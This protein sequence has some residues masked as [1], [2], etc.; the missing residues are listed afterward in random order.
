MS[1]TNHAFFPQAVRVLIMSAAASIAL[2]ATSVHAQQAYILTDAASNNLGLIDLASGNVTNTVTTSV[3]LTG[4]LVQT[5][6]GNFFGASAGQLYAVDPTSGTATPIGGAANGYYLASD[7]TSL[8]GIL[9]SDFSLLYSIDK[10]TGA[11]TVIGSGTGLPSTPASYGFSTANA[12]L[13]VLADTGSGDSL[14]YQID[15]VTGTAGVGKDTGV[16]G[17]DALTNVGGVL[18]AVNDTDQTIYQIDALSGLASPTAASLSA[19]FTSSGATQTT[20]LTPVPETG[21]A[22]AVLF[23]LAGLALLANRR[24][25]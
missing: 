8:Y 22:V 1:C 6:D 5:G 14:L 19:Y 2:A 15:T 18:Y 25:T 9:G 17:L 24:N 23:G 16:S 21:T 20:S 11:V 13:F 3:A 12:S 7:S 4:G 10:S